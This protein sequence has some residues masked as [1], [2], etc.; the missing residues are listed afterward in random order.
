MKHIVLTSIII[1]VLL[2]ITLQAKDIVTDGLV[3]YWTFD[4]EDIN[5]EIVKDLH[6]NNDATMVGDP[7]LARGIVNGALQ[8]DGVDDYVNL[9]NLG[10]FARNI[11]TSTFEIWIKTNSDKNWSTLFKIIDPE[12][13]MAWGMDINRGIKIPEPHNPEEGLHERR[14]GG[15]YGFEKD[16]ILA[17][18]GTY[19]KQGNLQL[20]S[21][22]VSGKDFPSTNHEWNHIVYVNGLITKDEFGH[23]HREMALY[24]N[25]EKNWLQRTRMLDIKTYQPFVESV[26]LGAG[27]NQDEIEGFYNGLIDEVRIYDRPLTEEEVLKNMDYA[28]T[29]SV[30]PTDKISTVWGK[31]KMK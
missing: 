23:K 31:L 24:L 29:Y 4:D 21:Y 18:K 19:I 28:T 26:F 2:P 13:G 10:D 22:S 12:C 16:I 9:T 20:R 7:K 11:E 3:S 27:N 14:C 1:T 17:H 30:K 8:F 6:G 5:G 25:G 15:N